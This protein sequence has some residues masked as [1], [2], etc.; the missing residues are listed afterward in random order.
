MTWHRNAVMGGCLSLQDGV[1]ALLVHQFVI[2][3]PA[4]CPDQ[5]IAGQIA[6]QSHSE[7]N[8]SS[9]TRCKRILDG[10]GRSKK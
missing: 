2:P 4:Q 6:G 10:L 3:I 7:T 8:T 9:R 5:F 1:A